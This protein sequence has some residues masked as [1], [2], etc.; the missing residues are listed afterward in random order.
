MDTLLHFG[1]VIED[2]HG[3]LLVSDLDSKYSWQQKHKMWYYSLPTSPIDV[4]NITLNADRWTRGKNIREICWKV[5]FN[6]G[7]KALSK[8][9]FDIQE[10]AADTGEGYDYASLIFTYDANFK[11][12]RLEYRY[13]FADGVPCDVVAIVDSK[14]QLILDN[15]AKETIKYFQED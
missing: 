11:A 5:N 9:I 8:S 10:I 6:D 12:T 1:W 14:S 7:E 15:L 2:A 4:S 3:N 13:Y